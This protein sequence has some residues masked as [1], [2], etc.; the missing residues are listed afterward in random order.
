MEN[1]HHLRGVPSFVR[2]TV[3]Y[4]PDPAHSHTLPGFSGSFVS[5]FRGCKRFAIPA[6]ANETPD[7]EETPTRALPALL[8]RAQLRPPLAMSGSSQKL[9]SWLPLLQGTG[10]DGLV[11][12][13]CLAACHP[14]VFAGPCVRPYAQKHPAPVFSHA[15]YSLFFN[16]L[17]ISVGMVLHLRN[18]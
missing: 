12:R 13:G 2:S 8:R 1:R 16:C 10:D 15:T 5:I 14:W 9:P 6:R 11:P 4:G 7:S 18:T 17:T 3:P